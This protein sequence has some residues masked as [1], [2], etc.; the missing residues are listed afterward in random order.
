MKRTFIIS[1]LGI[2]TLLLNSCICKSNYCKI[3][4]KSP[5]KHLIKKDTA[6]KIQQ[7][8]F[9]NQ[10]QVRMGDP[11]AIGNERSD[12][13]FPAK[14]LSGYLCYAQ[15]IANDKGYEISGYR[16]Y[17]GADTNPDGTIGKYKLFIVPTIKGDTS[18]APKTIM[19]TVSP[20]DNADIEADIN[21]DVP[22]FEQYFDISG[23][24]NPKKV[25]NS[26]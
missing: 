13:W 14:E 5:I 3:E 25:V 2:L 18:L 9:I 8:F 26:N 1:A 6:K 20:S 22:D 16:M 15:K 10:E 11:K 4:T 19:K 12:F 7:N 23:S 21:I 17:L 24:G